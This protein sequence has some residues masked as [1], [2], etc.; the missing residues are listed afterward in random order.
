MGFLVLGFRVKGSAATQPNHRG[1]RYGL[2]LRS[3][4]C[5]VSWWGSGGRWK[6]AEGGRGGMAEDQLREENGGTGVGP[7]KYRGKGRE[8]AAGGGGGLKQA[9]FGFICEEEK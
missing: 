8:G 4:T 1:W 5:E 6:E 2:G 9:R 7:E 3:C